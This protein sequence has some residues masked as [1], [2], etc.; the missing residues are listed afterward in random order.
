MGVPSGIRSRRNA[1]VVFDI[2]MQPCETAFPST[3]GSF[4]PCNADDAAARPL[5]QV[6]IGAR[7]EGE[8]A[9]VGRLH[10]L[11]ARGHVEEA[12]RRLHSRGSDGDPVRVDELPVLPE[13]DHA[14]TAKDDHL[15]RDRTDRDL[16]RGHPAR[17]A[18]RPAGDGDLVPRRLAAELL[19]R[20]REDVPRAVVLGP[21]LAQLR[22]NARVVAGSGADDELRHSDR[23]GADDGLRRRLADGER[24]GRKGQQDC[25]GGEDL[26]NAQ[27]DG[28]HWREAP[29]RGR[30]LYAETILT[31]VPTATTE[32]RYSISWL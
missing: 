23:A 26:G 2:R 11:E 1:A 20:H 7:L 30:E 12:G 27:R 6:R 19:L 25:G 17:A 8:G 31:G 14:G 3:D 29:G 10:R 18:V 13:L 16:G 9:Q 24:R 15:P 21:E 4:Q 28:G 32:R 5:R 22:D